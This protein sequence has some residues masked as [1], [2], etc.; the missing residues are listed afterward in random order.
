MQRLVQSVVAACES[1]LLPDPLVRLGMRHVIGA[2]L[3]EPAF[4][5]S[6]RRDQAF[7]Q[8][9]RELRAAPIAIETPRANEQHYEV[10]ASFFQAHLGPR[11]KYSCCLFQRG[12]ESLA[13]AEDAMLELYAE[14]AE[15]RDGQRVLDLGSGWGSFSLWLAAK[16]PNSEIVGLSNSHSQR[17]FVMSRAQT[18]G[19]SNLRIVTGNVAE[20]EFE[21][22]LLR[23]GFDR[24]V[25]IEMF[26]HMKN[27]E[28]LLAKIARWLSPEGKLFVHIFAH[29]RLAYHYEDRGSE[30]WMSRYF[31]T[32]GTMPSQNLLLHFQ[33]DLSLEDSWWLSGRHY[34]QTSNLWLASLDANRARALAAIEPVYGQSAERWFQRWRMFYM[35]VAELFGFAHGS[36]W[37]VAHYRFARRRTA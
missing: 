4:R 13:Q 24:V 28:L 23:G 6:E 33:D 19:L 2:R 7:R 11:A 9:L 17:A 26:E 22:E 1:G 32:G 15:L 31:F 18:L 8:F 25:S 37:G 3:R 30:D 16:H 5:T 14:R 12:D 20:F 27:Y 36:E 34:E 29:Q 35:A 21:A 10:P